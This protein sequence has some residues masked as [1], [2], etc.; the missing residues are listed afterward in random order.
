LLA[1]NG[2][3]CQR[4]FALRNHVIVHLDEYHPFWVSSF[5][6]LSL[7]PH[8]ARI[9]SDVFENVTFLF[10]RM[11]IIHYGS[12]LSI[13]CTSRMHPIVSAVS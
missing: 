7:S 11:N 2:P 3:H 12:F 5:S 9:V 10:I 4:R 6:M 13:P 1:T 8:V